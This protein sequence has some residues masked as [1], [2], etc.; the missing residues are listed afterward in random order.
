MD[1]D[2]KTFNAQH[3]TSKAQSSSLRL[4]VNLRA[5]IHKLLRLRLHPAF[6]RVL[7]AHALFGGVF[8]DVLGDFHRAEM[9]AAHGTKMGA[10]GAF[11]RQGFIV[12][13]AR[14][15][16]IEAQVELVFPAEFEARL[17]QRVVAILR[18]RMALGQ[19]RGVS[20]DFVGDDPVL[21]VFLVRQAEMLLGRDVAKHRAAVPADHRRADAAGDMVV[22]G[23]DVGGQRAER[24]ERRFVAPFELFGHV[25][26]DHVHRHMAGTFVHHLHALGPGALGQFALHFQ[27]AE[28]RA[29]VR[30]GNRAGTQ[31]VAD[32]KL[33]RHTRP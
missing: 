17:A 3:P 10:L 12:K 9:R 25:F 18:A 5:L 2:G 22:A 28:L 21:H 16:G 26:L 1:T 31:T 7:L 15:H 27:F 11:L 32:V 33:K 8:A 14:R 20:G 13:F 4:R 29:V 19:V 30:I 24:V 6:E 23:R